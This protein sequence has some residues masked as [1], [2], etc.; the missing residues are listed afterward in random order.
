MMHPD[1]DEYLRLAGDNDIVPVYR[2]VLA[3]T[4][5]PVSVLCRFAH[6]ENVFLLESMEGGET[7]ARYSFVGIDPEPFLEA[8]HSN[9]PSGDLEKIREIYRGLRVARVEGLERFFG[10]AVG[11]TGYEATGEFERMPVPKEAAPGIEARSRFLKADKIVMFDNIRHS[12][13]IIVCT[14]PDAADP[15]RTYESARHDIDRIE[16]TLS[17][18][19]HR[20]ETSEMGPAVFKSNMTRDEYESIVGR[21]RQYIFDGDIIQVVLSQRF[22]AATDIAPLQLYRA[23]RFLNPSPYTFFLKMG[24]RTLVGSSPEVMVRLTGRRVELRPIAGTRPRGGSPE[25]DICLEREL[26]DDEKEK[27]EH[28][29]LVDL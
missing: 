15:Q 2:E 27:A 12:V 5:T 22:S 13:K 26:L 25:E 4:E 19:A 28:V 14:R 21:A 24:G 20:P 6:R 8:D 29:M 11:F 10:G 1:K 16:K 17:S 7:W 3:D 23:L 18:P 9:G